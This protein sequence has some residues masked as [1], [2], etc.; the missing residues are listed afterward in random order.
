MLLFISFLAG[1]TLFYLFDYFPVSTMLIFVAFSSYVL[2]TRRIF[3]LP[4]LILGLIYPFMRGVPADHPPEIWNKE[5]VAIGQFHPV[6]AT[7]QRQGNTALTFHAESVLDP[8]SGTEID[9]L[10]NAEIMI[11]FD[12]EVTDNHTYELFIKTVRDRTRRNPGGFKTAKIYASVI[13]FSEGGPGSRSLPRIFNGFRNSLNSYAL[14]RFS[15]DTA[16]LITAVTTGER[17]Y[18]SRAVRKAFNNS[19]LAHM[20]SIS[21]TH[22]GLFSIMLFSV[23]IFAIH[24]LPYRLLQNITVYVTPAQLSAIVCIPFMLFYIGISG[25]NPPAIRSFIMISVFLAGLFFGRKGFWLHSLLFAAV[26][27]VLWEPHMILSLS[28]QLSFVAVLFIGFSLETADPTVK[29]ERAEQNQSQEQERADARTDLEKLV[30]EKGEKGNTFIR[31]IQKAFFIA[32]AASVGTAPLVAY[33]FHYLSVISPLTNLLVAPLIGFTVIPL[34]LVSSFTF[35]TTGVYIGAPLVEVSADFSLW[36]THVT[37]KIPYASFMIPAFPPIL[38][39]TFYTGFLF[40]VI[41]GKKRKLLIVPFL[42]FLIYAVFHHFDSRELTVHYLDVGQG[43]AAVVELPDRKTFL[44]DTG[45]TGIEAASF[46]RYR[47]INRIDA[48]ILSHVHPDHTG[49]LKQ[50]LDEFSVNELWDNGHITYPKEFILPASVRHLER[51]DVL[52]NG[53]YSITVLHPY[54]EFYTLFG[55]DYDAENNASLVLK[56]SGMNRSFLFSGDIEE[57]AEHDITYLDRWVKSDILKIPHHGSSTSAD[58]AFLKSV[59]P[60][61]VVISAG[62]GN[63]FGHPSQEVLE[64]LK[65]K[66]ILRTDRSGAIQISDGHNGLKMKTYDDYKL[67]K[68]RHPK[69]EWKNIKKLFTTW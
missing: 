56:L 45:R 10:K 53:S 33:H 34:A 11:F 8:A 31:Y 41:S 18:I 65:G 29:I 24:R 4:V 32:I 1:V 9:T 35:I 47:G 22:F 5:L 58:A 16:G 40:Y 68:T 12:K 63:A 57:E 36:L 67:K 66:R 14:K 55:A 46:L 42:P 21:G 23:S 30:K 38:L 61:V 37:A 64:R 27:L 50:I 7:A 2:L 69:E 52:N 20:L 26:L 17:S 15:P 59:A 54:R 28:F 13:S 51:G 43:D 19:G 60:S 39:I 62:R 44:I 48:L 49:G 25:G 3:F 6:P